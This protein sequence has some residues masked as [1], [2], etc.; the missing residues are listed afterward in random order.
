MLDIIIPY[1]HLSSLTLKLD[2][3]ALDGRLFPKLLVRHVC[4]LE[5]PYRI[6]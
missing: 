4:Q 2:G 1:V 6:F 5:L 3:P